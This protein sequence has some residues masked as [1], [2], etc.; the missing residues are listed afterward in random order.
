MNAHNDTTLTPE[1]FALRLK[2]SLKNSN[3]ADMSCR[4][5]SEVFNK[6]VNQ[7]Q[8]TETMLNDWLQARSIPSEEK[9]IALSKLLGVSSDWLITGSE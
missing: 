5:F 1:L 8:I 6:R 4:K 2:F 7:C 3:Y 9:M